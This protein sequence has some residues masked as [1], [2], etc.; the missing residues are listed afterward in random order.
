MFL[1]KITLFP[2]ILACSFVASTTVHAYAENTNVLP[3][4]EDKPEEP[5]EPKKPGK[6]TPR[7]QKQMNQK[8]VILTPKRK[9]PKLIRTK[10]IQKKLIQA[11]KKKQTRQILQSLKETPRQ[12]YRINRG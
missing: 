3:L 2:L 10:L 1:R 7:S 6:K 8:K 11:K 5:K 4:Q 12:D 9:K